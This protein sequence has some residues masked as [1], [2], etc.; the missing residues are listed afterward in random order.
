MATRRQRLE[1]F[2]KNDL[3]NKL[4]EQANKNASCGRDCFENQTK[5]NLK[6]KYRSA[7]ENLKKAPNDLFNARRNYFTYA[8]GQN[9]Y[10]N[11]RERQIKGIVNKLSE[12]LKA[13]HNDF[14]RVISNNLDSYKVSVT[15]YKN[16]LDLFDKYQKDGENMHLKLQAKQ[17]DYNLNARRVDYEQNEIDRMRF[18]LFFCIIIYFVCFGIFIVLF[19]YFKLYSDP[20]N[21]IVFVIS[22]IFP[23]LVPLSLHFIFKTSDYVK[24]NG[25]N[26]NVYLNGSEM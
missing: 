9:Y 1:D 17:N 26:F 25:T 21:L 23:F 7:A 16:M 3:A 13:N 8:F 4:I 14:I 12:K 24:E 20:R 22:I 15:Y 19:L 5:N 10:D 18:Y 2:A 6:N 11:Y